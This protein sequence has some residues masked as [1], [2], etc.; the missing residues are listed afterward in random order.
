M[1]LGAYCTGAHI[2]VLFMF[3]FAYKGNCVLRFD[4]HQLALSADIPIIVVPW[5]KKVA[6]RAAKSAVTAKKTSTISAKSANATI[7]NP[8][9]PQEEKASITPDTSTTIAKIPAAKVTAAKNT[10]LAKEIEKTLKP[11]LKKTESVAGVQKQDVN[12]EQKVKKEITPAAREEKKV[13]EN[14]EVVPVVSPL[15]ETDGQKPVPES[16]AV[17]H[18]EIDQENAL[19]IGSDELVAFQMQQDLQSQVSLQW[20][21]PVG[22]RSDLV[23][24]ITLSIDWNCQLKEVHVSKSSGVPMYDMSARQSLKDFTPPA[25][26]KG[27]SLTICF[28]Q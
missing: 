13:A 7:S 1:R 11:E 9:K 22:L 24:E 28:K 19:I 3:L 25:W 16:I 26:A 10:K 17:A 4:I 21:P 6:A 23:C 15:V 14:K 5:C 2:V 27:K 8:V 18:A 20:K 12:D